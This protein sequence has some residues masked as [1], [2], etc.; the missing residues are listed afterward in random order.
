[1]A[2]QY[3][4]SMFGMDSPYWKDKYGWNFIKDEPYP[5][6]MS[7]IQENRVLA[8]TLNAVGITPDMTLWDIINK[9]KDEKGDYVTGKDEEGRDIYNKDLLQ[10]I[11]NDAFLD[12]GVDV[13]MS[14]GDI[15]SMYRKL[16]DQRGL[17]LKP[18]KKPWWVK[19]EDWY[20]GPTADIP[21]LKNQPAIVGQDL[22]DRTF[23]ND[24]DVVE[25]IEWVDPGQQVGPERIPSFDNT[26]IY[27]DDP[28]FG[29]IQDTLRHERWLREEWVPD[30]SY[31]ELF[32]SGWIEEAEERAE[33]ERRDKRSQQKWD[34]I[35]RARQYDAIAN[36]LGT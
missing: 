35:R 32:E 33:K 24:D 1:M 7:D 17:L 9:Y 26:G 3:E 25:T 21:Y 18:K 27:S 11:L 10:S 36:R 6:S 30:A 14:S 16:L 31:Q 12:V 8:E 19:K 2:D 22:W 29:P 13:P 15:N 28:M 20:P 4:A 5:D 23:G 34:A